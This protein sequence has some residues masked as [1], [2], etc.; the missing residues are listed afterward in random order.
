[1]VAG[2]SGG[3]GGRGLVRDDGEGSDPLFRTY[4]PKF[5]LPRMTSHC[6]LHKGGW[7][8]IP[9]SS[10]L[11]PPPTH[12][13]IHTLHIQLEGVG[14]EPVD[15]HRLDLG[16]VLP[17]DARLLRHHVP[18]SEVLPKSTRCGEGGGGRRIVRRVCRIGMQAKSRQRRRRPPPLCSPLAHIQ[19]RTCGTPAPPAS[20]C[21]T[22]CTACLRVQHPLPAGRR[23][24]W[25]GPR[26]PEGGAARGEEKRE[27]EGCG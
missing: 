21:C 25:R 16:L 24:H 1:M 7:Y 27:R 14:C 3:K 26:T 5:L 6:P 4:A 10:T 15:G 23:C 8:R 13:T 11:A 2:G 12:F 9:S 19:I 22:T 18:H 20:R 17:L